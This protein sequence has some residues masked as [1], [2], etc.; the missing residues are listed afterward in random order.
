MPNPDLLNIYVTFPDQPQF[1]DLPAF[2]SSVKTRMEQYFYEM[3]SGNHIVNIITMIRPSP[4][5]EDR[6]IADNN[7]GYY[8]D[9]MWAKWYELIDEI[10]LKVYTDSKHAI[11]SKHGRCCC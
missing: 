11:S 1:S 8:N 6:Y 7:Y 10:L 9:G 2:H 4:F 5:H 3:S